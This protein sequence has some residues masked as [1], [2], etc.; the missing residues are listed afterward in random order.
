MPPSKYTIGKSNAQEDRLYRRSG[1]GHY[2][3][4]CVKDSFHASPGGICSNYKRADYPVSSIINYATCPV[5]AAKLHEVQ[6]GIMGR[7]NLK[8]SGIW[9]R[10]EL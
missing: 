8:Q 10:A 9:C 3:T 6:R 2:L 4:C 7:R 5:R 1:Q